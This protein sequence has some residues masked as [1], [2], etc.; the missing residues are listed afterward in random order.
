VSTKLSW[1]DS[2]WT[3]HPNSRQREICQFHPVVDIVESRLALRSHQSPHR[4]N[5]WISSSSF[6]WSHA[7]MF[8]H[9]SNILRPTLCASNHG[10]I[11][12]RAPILN[13]SPNQHQCKSQVVRGRPAAFRGYSGHLHRR[14]QSRQWHPHCRSKRAPAHP[15]QHGRSRLG[16]RLPSKA[17]RKVPRLTWARRDR[18]PERPCPRRPLSGRA[19]RASLFRFPRRPTIRNG[20]VGEA[21]QMTWAGEGGGGWAS[22]FSAL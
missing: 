6:L 22:A 17:E 14:S 19:P 18:L 8:F 11:K 12:V 13:V 20:T 15:P 10:V 1:R 9:I 7:A 2:G 5:L 4:H 21:R 16:S 3:F